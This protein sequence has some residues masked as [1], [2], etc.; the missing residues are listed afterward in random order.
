MDGQGLEARMLCYRKVSNFIQSLLILISVLAIDYLHDLLSEREVLMQ[1]LQVARNT[2]PANHPL[3][4]LQPDALLP[5]WERKWS[6]GEEIG[7]D[8]DD[9]DDDD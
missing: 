5:L 9:N 8:D 7:N 6:G 1:R 3:L 4:Q 2:L